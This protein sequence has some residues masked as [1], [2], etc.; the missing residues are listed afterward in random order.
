M[1]KNISKNLKLLQKLPV[2]DLIFIILANIPN[3]T[4]AKK[5]EGAIANN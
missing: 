1:R 2:P 3:C 4:R 5:T